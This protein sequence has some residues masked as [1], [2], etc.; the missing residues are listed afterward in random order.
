MDEDPTVK[1]D[2]NEKKE[3]KGYATQSK[4]DT[5]T[6]THVKNSYNS[7]RIDAL[8]KQHKVTHERNQNDTINFQSHLLVQHKIN[9]A[10]IQAK[11]KSKFDNLFEIIEERQKKCW[12][13]N[14]W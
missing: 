4:L 2:A 13:S 9:L 11:D 12:N 1:Q 7:S 5:I 10:K 8:T 14:H 6:T 3:S